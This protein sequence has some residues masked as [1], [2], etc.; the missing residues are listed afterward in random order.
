[1]EILLKNGI[2]PIVLPADFVNS[3][4]FVTGRLLSF[5]PQGATA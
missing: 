3:H 4:V 2:L 5:L 1:M